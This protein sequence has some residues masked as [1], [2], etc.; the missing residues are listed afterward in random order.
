MQ[1]N[2]SEDQQAAIEHWL[3][4]DVY[5]LVIAEQKKNTENPDW[6]YTYSW[7]AGYPYEGAIGGGTSYCFTAT[8]I[9]DILIVRYDTF[10]QHFEKDF[11]EYE[12]W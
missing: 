4:E 7:A 1:F 5:P 11:T 12:C 2:V 3:M 10:T 9:G 6:V 8:S